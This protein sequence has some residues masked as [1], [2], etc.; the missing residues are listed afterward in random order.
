MTP[1]DPERWEAWKESQE[2]TVK[3]K[4]KQNQ[5][6]TNVGPRCCVPG[7]KGGGKANRCL[8]CCGG[9]GLRRG[10]GWVAPVPLCC[11]LG[12][13]G[14]LLECS[15]LLG[16]QRDPE[17]FVTA[18]QGSG[19]GGVGEKEAR[20]PSPRPRLVMHFLQP[21][22]PFVWRF[23]IRPLR[24]AGGEGSAPGTGNSLVGGPDCCSSPGAGPWTLAAP[25]P[26]SACVLPRVLGAE[27]AALGGTWTLSTRHP[28]G[29]SL[30]QPVWLC[31]FPLGRG[32]GWK[33]EGAPY[34]CLSAVCARGNP[35]R[36]KKTEFQFSTHDMHISQDSNSQNVH[37]RTVFGMRAYTHTP[38]THLSVDLICIG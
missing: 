2:P 16:R 22:I 8:S 38:H 4:Q 31:G 27:P 15:Q 26:R 13:G 6:K 35:L 18:A 19:K 5:N 37:C 12:D 28:R 25:G 3:K 21:R 36:M 7:R 14:F 20:H 10:E 9:Q 34:F 23:K 32:R 33:N 24:A 29:W 1:W 17:G 11:G 30:A